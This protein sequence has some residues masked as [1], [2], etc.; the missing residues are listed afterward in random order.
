MKLIDLTVTNYKHFWV[1]KTVPPVFVISKSKKTLNGI[2]HKYLKS[3]RK[4]IIW[5]LSVTPSLAAQIDK[6]FFMASLV[7][8]KMFSK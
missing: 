8:P 3:S 4:V 1:K 5:P 7:L 2:S 6:C